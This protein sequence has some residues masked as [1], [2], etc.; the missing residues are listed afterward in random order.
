MIDPI[1]EFLLPVTFGGGTDKFHCGHN[2]DPLKMSHTLLLRWGE[3]S[4][5]R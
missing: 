2:P 3:E 5:P 1:A 4:D